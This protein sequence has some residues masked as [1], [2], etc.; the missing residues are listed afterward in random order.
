[1]KKA[2]FTFL[3]GCLTVA[4]FAQEQAVYSHYQVFP[5][6]INPAYTGFEGNHQLLANARSTWT[7]F[8]GRPTTYTLLYNGPV[9]DKLALGGGIFSEKVGDLSTLKFQVNYAFRF[10]VQKAKIGLG[11]STEFLRRQASADLL[12]D[13]T[14]DRNDAVL[15]GLIDGQQI[16]DASIGAHM[17]YDNRLFIGLTLPN[18]VRTRL[19]EVPVD[20]QTEGSSS[21]LQ[22]YVFQLGYQLNVPK[23]NFMVIPSLTMRKFRDTPYQI[24]LNVQGRFME[25]KLIAGLT[26]RPNNRGAVAFQLGTR[27]NSFQVLYAYDVSFG[28]FQQY[29]GGS[30]EVTVAYSLRKGGKSGKGTPTSD[31]Y[32]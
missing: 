13:P 3:L 24:D 32:Q 28:P 21:L 5:I 10:Q 7:G 6:L 1:M 20:E 11:L 16:F 30:H 23:Q 26:F 18:T 29:N 31:L 12:T 25:E 22:H 14:V 9:S 15:E 27:H 19:D 17:L 8:P 4:A 2:F